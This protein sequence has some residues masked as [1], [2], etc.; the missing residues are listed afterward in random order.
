MVDRD[1]KTA[2]SSA[3]QKISMQ[4]KIPVPAGLSR[5][6]PSQVRDGGEHISS[7]GPRMA[8]Q[9]YRICSLMVR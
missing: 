9:C 6:S 4:W 1:L 8:G 2:L 3:G 7:T 5:Q